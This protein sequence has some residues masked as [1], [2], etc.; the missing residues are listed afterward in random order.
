MSTIKVLGHCPPDTDSTCSPI[1]YA[2]FLKTY[3]GLDAEAYICGNPN[4]EAEFVLKHFGLTNPSRIEKV[5]AEDQLVLIDTNNPEEL[6]S[7]WE[8]AQIIEIVDHHKLYGL[9][10]SNIPTVTVRPY[11]CVATVIWEIMMSTPNV[12]IPKEY[13]GLLAACILSDTLKFTSPTTTEIDKTAAQA[14]ATIAEL[15]IDTFAAEMFAAKSNLE[16]MSAHDVLLT[17]A[18]DFDFNQK[19]FK[20]AVLETTNPQQAIDRRAELEAEMKAVKSADNLA[21]I[22]FFVVDIINSE[23]VA[24]TTD[25]SEVG[26]IEQAFNVQRDATGL[27]K[28]PGIV[29]RKKQI[30]P[31]IEKAVLSIV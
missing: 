9:K 4:R 19:L 13:A 20:L 16:G 10:T 12:V 11:G 14:L 30:V 6:V 27:V 3:R 26:I 15:D 8:E 24:I 17:D 31:A 23:A 18:K 2:W 5:G 21:G 28:L 25:E 29:S 7:G 1:A 22:M